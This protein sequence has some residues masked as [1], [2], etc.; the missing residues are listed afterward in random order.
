MVLDP[1]DPDT[2][3]V[4]SFFTNPVVARAT[5]ERIA[6]A[7]HYLMENDTVK[8]PAA[9]LIEQSGFARGHVD[10]AVGLSTKH[11]L[12]IV[13]R[14]GATARDVLRL[15]RRIKVAVRDRFD[16]GLRPEPVFVGFSPDDDDVS[17]LT[18]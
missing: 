2:R 5:F 6:P 15:A 14:G 7:P 12:A 4:G 9:W 17:F 8:I 1:A 3:S 11:P 18:S 13:N 16:V 10:G